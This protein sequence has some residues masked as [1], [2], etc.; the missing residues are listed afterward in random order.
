V[1]SEAAYSFEVVGRRREPASVSIN[2][3]SLR[4]GFYSLR[5]ALFI[6]SS[7]TPVASVSLEF[8][9]IT[10]QDRIAYRSAPT[11]A[12]TC[13]DLLLVGFAAMLMLTETPLTSVRRQ[14]DYSIAPEFPRGDGTL[15]K[16]KH[17]DL[18]QVQLMLLLLLSA[19]QSFVCF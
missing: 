8:M 5:L 3:N 16:W 17:D 9:F 4:D 6:G 10:Q 18:E 11:S 7:S 2:A 14:Q 1:R 13:V 15:T 19:S 12:F